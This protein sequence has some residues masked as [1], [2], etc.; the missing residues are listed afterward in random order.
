MTSLGNRSPNLQGL[1]T[2]LRSRAA[3]IPVLSLCLSIVSACGGSEQA[4]TVALRTV[5]PTGEPTETATVQIATSTKALPTATL[6]ATATGTP[7][8]T[9]TPSP[10]ATPTATATSTAT[11][12]PEPTATPTPS[13]IPPTPTVTEGG[14]AITGIDFD[15]AV[16]RDGDGETV[17][18]V[19]VGEGPVDMTG[20]SLSDIA[21]HIYIFPNFVLQP[22]AAVVVHIC[23]GENTPE[24]L[25]WGRCSAIWN[26]EGDT[27]YLRDATGRGI[28]TYSY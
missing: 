14:V 1:R 21:E 16:G 11:A 23:A 28:S 25:F 22:G 5:A 7:P 13:P 12:T 2:A 18:I 9:S 8:P 27:A 3:W 24:I 10:P 26:N 20:W 6:A 17:T 19:N 4:A 15:P